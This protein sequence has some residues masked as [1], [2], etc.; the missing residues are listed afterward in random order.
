VAAGLLE[1]LDSAKYQY[2][3]IDPEGDY[4]KL[5]GAV[6]LGSSERAP[7]LEEVLNVL[8]SDRNAVVNLLGVSVADRPGVFQQLFPTLLEHRSRTG[9]PHWVVLD[10]AHHLMRTGWAPAS[11]HLSRRLH[12]LLLITVHPATVSRDV[13]RAVDLVLAM[14]TDPGKTVAEFCQARGDLTP[15]APPADLRPG[16][17]VAYWPARGTP[18]AAL[19]WAPPKAER[20]RHSRKYAEGRLPE[21]R[22]F[23]FRGP[24]GKLHLR[25]YN[26]MTFLEL[27]EGVDDATWLHH[28]RGHEYSKWLREAIKDDELARDVEQAESKFG[29]DAAASRAAVR[30]AIEHRYTLPADA[31]SGIT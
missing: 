7:L 2:A 29:K 30:K 17:A 15:C 25:A 26:L 27:A 31:P 21:D 16:E 18:P 9:R 5:P 19:A 10:E 24:R 13:L 12:G 23:V 4:A 20:R 3:V 14:G 8:D 28:L 1:R 22:S 11:D 6:V